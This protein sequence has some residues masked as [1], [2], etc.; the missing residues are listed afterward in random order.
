MTEYQKTIKDKI[1]FS[2]TGIHTGVKTNMVLVPAKE[3]TG[4]F[5]LEQT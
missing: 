2:G 1:Y 5:L 4:I 3:N